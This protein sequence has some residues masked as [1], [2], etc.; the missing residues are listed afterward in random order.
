MILVG[1]KFSTVRGY[2][3]LRKFSTGY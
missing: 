2:L 3:H 1:A